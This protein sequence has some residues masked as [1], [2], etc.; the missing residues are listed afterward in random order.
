MH[1]L[2]SRSLRLGDCFGQK[3]PTPGDI[4]YFVSS[5]ELLPRAET[6]T[7]GGHLIKVLPAAAGTEPRQHNVVVAR[8]N[9]RLTV[10]P[11]R[12]EINA[13]DGVLWH[14]TDPEVTGFHVAGSG[15]GFQ[16][17]SAS[18]RGESVFTHAFGV[19]G[20][21]EWIDPNG[22]GVGGTIDV[23]AALCKGSDERDRWFEML[24]KPAGIKIKGNASSPATVS[25]TVGQ[26]VFWSITDSPGVAILDK[27]LHRPSK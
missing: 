6:R 10:D 12:L 17:N 4:R 2:D 22:T 5:G 15:E 23:E 1:T 3:F 19:P 26:T 16:F 14:T 20:R 21:Y 11:A 18:I 24:K 9:G 8:A 13:G 7:E 27:R 25:I